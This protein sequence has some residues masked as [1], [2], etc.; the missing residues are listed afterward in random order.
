MKRSSGSSFQ[1]SVCLNHR[2]QIPSFLKTSKRDK[3][4]VSWAPNKDNLNTC[5]FPGY[6]IP[7]IENNCSVNLLDLIYSTDK[8]HNQNTL[9]TSLI[10]QPNPISH[11][12]QFSTIAH[13]FKCRKTKLKDYFTASCPL[14]SFLCIKSGRLISTTAS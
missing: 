14:Y 9:C 7:I 8:D 1:T 12:L 6:G 13:L 4:R 2:E 3:E 11:S 10:P 5:Y